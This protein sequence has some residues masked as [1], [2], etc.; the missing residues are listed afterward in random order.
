MSGSDVAP[1]V[2]SIQTS[3][4]DFG[5]SYRLQAT[6]AIV[7][8]ATTLEA[9]LSVLENGDRLGAMFMGYES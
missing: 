9:Q 5:G 2:T 1:S 6:G 3:A 7:N 8:G 4:E